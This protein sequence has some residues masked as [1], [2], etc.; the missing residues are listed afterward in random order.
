M[1]EQKEREYIDLRQR[2]GNVETDGWGQGMG[3]R[4]TCRRGT[5]QHR[6]DEQ[7]DQGSQGQGT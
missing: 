7:M 6:I 1:T 4:G 3:G 5:G 2:W